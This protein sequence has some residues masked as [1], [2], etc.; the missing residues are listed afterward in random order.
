MHCAP[1]TPST[2]SVPTISRSFALAVAGSVEEI[3]R[4]YA[5]SDLVAFAQHSQ[6]RALLRLER[7][8]D[9]VD[10]S[11]WAQISIVGGE[12]A[13]LEDAR[14]RLHELEQAWSPTLTTRDLVR[15]DARAGLVTAVSADTVL[16][17]RLAIRAGVESRGWYD[18]TP[19]ATHATQP[20]PTTS[21]PRLG[22]MV[23]AARGEVR[24]SAGRL[25]RPEALAYGLA[26]DLIAS[27]LLDAGAI[28]V[29]VDVGGHVH[30]DGPAPQ[31]EGWLVAVNHPHFRKRSTAFACARAG[32][33]RSV[34]ATAARGC[35][36]PS[37]AKPRGAPRH[38]PGRSRPP[39]PRKDCSCCTTAACR[40]CSVTTTAGSS[41]FRSGP[42]APA[43]RSLVYLPEPPRPPAD[44]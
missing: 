26:A 28:G 22:L 19:A 13:D 3:G 29:C 43:D 16:L 30:A 7:L 11:P 20:D 24:L 5:D 12:V 27:D 9:G 34:A 18:P 33:R 23:D 6:G 25:F 32:S 31:P 14:E 38:S 39:D 37:S 35:S 42:P 10:G 4:R 15:L 40:G 21:N 17:A 41:A 2:G 8:D 44:V 1:L 36:S